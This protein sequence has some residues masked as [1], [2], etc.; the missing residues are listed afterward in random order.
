MINN[1]GKKR[2]YS[3]PEIETVSAKSCDVMISSG[4]EQDADGSYKDTWE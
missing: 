2:I 4:I 1:I 3:V